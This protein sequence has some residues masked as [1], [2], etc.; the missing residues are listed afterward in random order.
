[1]SLSRPA[2][3]RPAPRAIARWLLAVAAVVLL[4]VV[5]G[6]I[7]RLTES[8]LSMTR[9]E[10]ISGTV[11]PL[12]DA[13]WAAEFDA[14]KATPEYAQVNR[15]MALAEFKRIFFWEYLHRLIGRSIGLIF[16]LPLLWFWWKRA[17]PAGYGPRLVAL[18]ALGGLQGAI[19]WW[20]VASGL[21]DRPDVSHFRLA[22]HL[23]AALFIFSG[24]I[25]TALDLR[26]GGPPARPTRGAVAAVA[27]L[28]IQ[29]ILGA[30]TA[31]LDAGF[32]FNE[33]PLMGGGLFP[34]GGWNPVAGLAANLS[35]NPIVVQ[36][37]HRWFA[38]AAAAA[39]A[40]LA[41]RAR[42]AAPAAAAGIVALV[43]LQI[44]LG[45]ATLLTVVA[46]PVA[47]AHQLVATLLL[48]AAVAA[49]HALG[50]GSGGF[51]PRAKRY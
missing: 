5:V 19:G 44:A 22:T 43:A 20:M 15:G 27:V 25:W 6:G 13:Q 42:R 3:P 21:I 32:L 33:W 36:F 46:L 38:W 10:P 28:A 35:S 45:V 30:F 24:L 17:I 1:M 40:A 2:G 49:A 50:H 4:M 47:V 16:A 29:I 18:L 39:L 31:G 12:N 7:T 23:L 9:W 26:A 51:A 14:Y 34:A 37:V 11:P 48:G 8:G 41:W